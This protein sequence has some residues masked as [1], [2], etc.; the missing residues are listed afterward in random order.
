MLTDPKFFK[1][2]N[3]TQNAAEFKRCLPV[4]VNTSFVTLAPAIAT[5]EQNHVRPLLGETLFN[6]LADYYAGNGI[7]GSSEEKNELV[8][9]IQM[10]VVRLAYWESFD[11]LAVT[12]SDRGLQVTNGENRAY[13]YQEDR[14]KLSLQRQGFGYLNTAIGYI[15]EHFDTFS[16]FSESEYYSE[17]QDSVIRSMKEMESITS[18][19]ND[20]CLFARLRQ[21]ISETENME[22]PFRIGA[23]LTKLLKTDR[24]TAR[25]KTLLRSAQGFVAHWTLAEALPALNVNMS[26]NGPVVMSDQGNGGNGGESINPIAPNLVEKLQK[27]H[28]EYAE[29]YI[30]QLVTYCKQ[31]VKTYPEIAEIGLSTAHEKTA[32]HRDNRGKKT[33]LA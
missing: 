31:H 13:R 5:A 19:G 18:I 22:L 16:S 14:L 6:E 9:Y 10:A 26:P 7:E 3:N 28:R 24:D 17:R 29:R 33:F 21:F 12:M 11:Q 15:M 30:G 4:N 25:L 20:F 2:E 23:S 1:K 27:N 32:G 8:S